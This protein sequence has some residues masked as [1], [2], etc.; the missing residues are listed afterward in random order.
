MVELGVRTVEHGNLA[1]DTAVKAMKKAG[2]Y[3]VANL[4]VYEVVAQFGR[5]HGFSGSGVGAAA[6][7]PG[8]GAALDRAMRA[9]RH[10]GR[11]RVGSREG[12]GVPVG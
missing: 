3:L 10:A 12:A 7:N 11:I 2:A 8:C 1:D 4:I 9:I 5:Q 6:D